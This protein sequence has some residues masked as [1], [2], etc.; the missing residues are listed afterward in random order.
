MSKEEK[1]FYV[2]GFGDG[3]RAAAAIITQQANEG[4]APTLRTYAVKAFADAWPVGF[5]YEEIISQIDKFYSDSANVRLPVLN[6]L[7]VAQMRFDGTDEP[8]VQARINSMRKTV[9]GK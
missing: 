8:T 1:L 7:E 9:A 2:R 6:A 4:L 3:F 5:T